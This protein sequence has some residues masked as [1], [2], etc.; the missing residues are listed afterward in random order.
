MT[1]SADG[2]VTRMSCP[3]AIRFGSNTSTKARPTA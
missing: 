1:P 2:E 3:T